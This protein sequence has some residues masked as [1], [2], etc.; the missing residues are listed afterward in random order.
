MGC[1]EELMVTYSAFLLRDRAKEWWK[2]LQRRYPE[3]IT[4]FFRLKQGSLS[5][6][7][8]EKKFSNLIRV[9]RSSLNPKIRAYVSS[10]AYTQFGLLVEAATRVERSMA[11]IPRPKE[12]KHGWTGGSQGGP[13]KTAKTEGAQSSQASIKPAIGFRGTR[14][15]GG[16]FPVCNK[17]R[18]AHPRECQKGNTGCYRCGQEGYFFRDCPNVGSSRYTSG[19]RG[20]QRGGAQ[21]R[22]PSGSGQPNRGAGRGGPPRG[23]RG[24]PHVRARVFAVTQQKA[25]AVLEVVTVAASRLQYGGIVSYR[26]YSTSRQSLLG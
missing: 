24:R 2:T 14:D 10:V 13:S 16:S 20:Q 3:E 23:Q 7:E 21:P 15:S 25:D 18:K 9:F 5:V 17:C 8:Y 6:A 19:D 26:G 11:V 22:G 12:Q 1:T 4:W